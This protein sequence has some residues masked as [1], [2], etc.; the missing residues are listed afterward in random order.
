MQDP[1]PIL[2]LA[3]IA[4]MLPLGTHRVWVFMVL[5]L[6]CSIRSC[7]YCKDKNT[8]RSA[9]YSCQ[10]AGFPVLEMIGKY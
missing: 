2:A 4:V 3:F 8:Q 10:P 9:R 7:E 5:L 6:L 1:V